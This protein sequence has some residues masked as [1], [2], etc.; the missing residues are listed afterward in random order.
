MSGDAE[1]YKRVMVKVEVKFNDNE[2]RQDTVKTIEAGDG[3]K[4]WL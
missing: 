1:G 2:T 3:W 4:I